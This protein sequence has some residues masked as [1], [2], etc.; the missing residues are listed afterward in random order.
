MFLEFDEAKE[1]IARNLT[2]DVNKY[3]NLFETTIRVLGGLLSAYHL[4]GER[5]FLEKAVSF[6][7]LSAFEVLESVWFLEDSRR[8][9]HWCFLNG[10][11]GPLQ[12]R[13]SSNAK[14]KGA[15]VGIR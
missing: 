12:R 8:S 10:F 11:N 5:I 15:F 6:P 3:V 1:W 14:S 2:F 9:P 4:S 13:E 7:F